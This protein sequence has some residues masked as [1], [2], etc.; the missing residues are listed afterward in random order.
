[1]DAVR[2]LGVVGQQWGNGM[3]RATVVEPAL[4]IRVPAAR[5]AQRP[6]RVALVHSATRATLEPGVIQPT[7]IHTM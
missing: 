3:A 4:V 5:A 6:G 7:K 2:L 1:M